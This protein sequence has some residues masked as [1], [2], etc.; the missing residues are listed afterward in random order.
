MSLGE[1]FGLWD[2][3]YRW[4]LLTEWINR[5]T[6]K[7]ADRYSEQNEI[8]DKFLWIMDTWYLSS[9]EKRR[10]DNVMNATDVH[11]LQKLTEAKRVIESFWWQQKWMWLNPTKGDD[12][13]Y[14]TFT[15]WLTNVEANQLPKESTWR[16]MVDYRQGIDAWKR[17]IWTLFNYADYV[18]A[19]AEFFELDLSANTW[20]A[21]KDVDI[22]RK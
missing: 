4:G 5:A 11:W 1:V 19:Y 3:K 17:D 7:V 8:I 13:W 21:L 18:K 14:K 16:K 12:Y 15:K 10:I 2:K 20:E 9:E 22:S 6:W